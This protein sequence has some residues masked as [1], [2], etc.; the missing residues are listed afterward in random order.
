MDTGELWHGYKN[1]GS[2]LATVQE[3]KGMLGVL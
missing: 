3:V 2:F 1:G